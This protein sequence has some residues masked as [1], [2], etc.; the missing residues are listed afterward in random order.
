MHLPSMC[1]AL[2]RLY[3]VSCVVCGVWCVVYIQEEEEKGGRA[4]LS[5]NELKPSL[6]TYLI[7]SHK[8]FNLMLQERIC[9]VGSRGRFRQRR[10]LS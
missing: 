6:H 10:F 5:F 1:K 9:N 7:L 3:R 8:I 4:V 2:R